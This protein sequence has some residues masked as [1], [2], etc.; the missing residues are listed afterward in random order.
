MSELTIGQLMCLRAGDVIRMEYTD[1]NGRHV[2]REL[3]V[4]SMSIEE[5]LF[6]GDGAKTPI[7]RTTNPDEPIEV[8]LDYTY[9]HLP[10]P[11]PWKFTVREKDDFVILGND[12]SLVG[13]VA[14]TGNE[15]KE[16]GNL[17]AAAPELLEACKAFVHHYENLDVPKLSFLFPYKQAKKLVEKLK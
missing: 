11:G 3:K 12:G 14:Y 7:V 4:A 6:D 16:N 2:K 5:H 1:D 9:Q 17:M 13:L 8:E 10:T 15:T